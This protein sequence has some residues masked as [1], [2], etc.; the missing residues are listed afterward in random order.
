MIS[1]R[2]LTT[3]VT[4]QSRLGAFLAGL[5]CFLLTAVAASS[6]AQAATI[7][8]INRDFA[9]EGF[10]DPTPVASVGGNFGTT[11]G[12]QR[13]NAF[14]FAANL[15]GA[16][17]DSAV[18]IRVGAN[19]DPQFCSSSSAILGSAGPANVARDFVGAPVA[20]T[21]FPIALANALHGSD[22]NPGGDD[23]TATFNSAIGT[24]CAFPLPWYY[25]LDATPPGNQIDFVTVVLHELGHGL[26]FLT[27]VDL[28]TGAKLS[29]LDD[30]YMRNLENHTT[31]KLYPN[32][33]DAE[34][35]TANTNTSNL[36]WVGAQVRAASGVLAAGRVNDHVQMFA[37]NPPQSGSSV[38]HF[39]TALAP[40]E[41]MEPIYTGP[42]HTPGLALPLFEDIGWSVSSSSTVSLAVTRTGTGTGTVSSLPAGINCGTTCSASFTTGSAVMPRS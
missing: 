42:R 18:E 1:G 6:I 39:A 13:L 26:G 12:T 33:T 25:G 35:A 24:T 3:M 7:T 4:Y 5:T 16:L 31:G 23:I 21:W 2:K 20:N 17:I 38:S 36:H 30:V 15:W 10:N 34:R 11:L 32:M 19:F 27:F 29:G 22:M 40:N 41:V 8:V 9:G 37:P 28:T 14:Q